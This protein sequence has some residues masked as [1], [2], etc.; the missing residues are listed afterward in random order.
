MSLFFYVKIEAKKG[1]DL[2][3]YPNYTYP[4]YGGYNPVTPF[5]PQPAMPAMNQPTMPQQP[6]QGQ[7]PGFVCRPVASEEEARAVPTDF[8]GATLILTDLGHGKIYTKALNYADGSAAFYTYQRVQEVPGVPAPQEWAPASLVAQVDNLKSEV[9]A[10]RAELEKARKPAGR[11]A[12]E[13]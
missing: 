7:Q 13:E 12:A 6:Q 11:K 8:S 9:E 1:A 10:L 5:A 2:M 4:V 3:G